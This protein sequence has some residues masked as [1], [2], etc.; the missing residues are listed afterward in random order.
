MTVDDLIKFFSEKGRTDESVNLIRII[1]KND[2][3]ARGNSSRA[4]I[5]MFKQK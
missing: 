5:K 2:T 3:E 1:N 4:R